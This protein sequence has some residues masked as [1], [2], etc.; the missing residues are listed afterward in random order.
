M[1]RAQVEDSL[2]K[3]IMAGSYDASLEMI[4]SA[5]QERLR[6]VF[7][8]GTAVRLQNTKDTALEGKTG[9]VLKVN[10]RRIT[11]GVGTMVTEGAGTPWAH[12][13]YEGGEYNL[14]PRMLEVVK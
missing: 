10:A 2:T 13:R 14:P 12:T 4:G 3:E 6:F 7:R 9:T 1:A 5:V 8:K 11:V